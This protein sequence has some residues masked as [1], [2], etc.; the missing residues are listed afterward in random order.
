MFE[1]VSEIADLSKNSVSIDD[2]IN[3]EIDI[4]Y[5]FT[6]KLHTLICP[7]ELAINFIYDQN[8]NML[9]M[10]E[11][12][13]GFFES[14]SNHIIYSTWG[15]YSYFTISVTGIVIFCEIINN[16]ADIITT[17]HYI[18]RLNNNIGR[19]ILNE[20]KDARIYTFENIRYITNNANLIGV[21]ENI[22]EAYSFD[23]FLENH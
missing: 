1:D 3:A 20:V 10:I 18:K 12:F 6:Y 5:M 2:V 19:D 11:E 23:S 8:L 22:N 14:M 17:I 7:I 4:L 9:N 13:I 16:R 21:I 15:K